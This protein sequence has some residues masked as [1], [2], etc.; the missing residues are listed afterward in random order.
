M[1]EMAAGDREVDRPEPR[2]LMV[3][4]ERGWPQHS[5]YRR[6]VAQVARALASVGPTT[7]VVSPRSTFDDGGPLELPADLVGRVETVLVPAID[8][9][10]LGTALW[11]LSGG[12]PW[13]LAAGDWRPVVERLDR[14]RSGDSGRFDVVW[15]MGFDAL[16]AAELAGFA[17][18]VT[19]VDADL[20][21]LK[22]ERALSVDGEVTGL[23]RLIARTD[24]DRWRRLEREAAD[25]LTGFSVCSDGERSEVGGGA[26]TT[27]NSYRAIAGAEE[28]RASG[29]GSAILFVGSL[30]YAPNADGLGWFVDEVLPTIRSER[31]EVELRV[32]GGG[33]PANSRLAM[34]EGVTVLGSIPDLSDELATAAMAIVPIRWGAGTR[35]KIL[36]AFAH[37]LPVVSTTLGAEGLDVE[38]E[39][40][41]LLADDPERL[42]EACDRVLD[43]PTA[44]AAM[45]KR[46]NEHF[47]ANYEESAVS[48]RLALR[49]EELLRANPKA[50]LGQE[51][52][53][54]RR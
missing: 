54:R 25:L 32:V 20:E 43:G 21:S 34:A 42:A 12:Q 45:A 48:H 44:A 14:M 51:P 41:L 11:W 39:T 28:R 26:F 2:L 49:I 31:P 1:G 50:E 37:H 19:I 24:V 15:A 47:M 52:P 5:G 8:R 9:P 10:R 4:N 46:A 6:R 38:H 29:G 16:T 7:M 53:G 40:H 27:P 22:L 23:R 3:S 36:E 13:P 18:P 35:I 33:L 17:A 30:G